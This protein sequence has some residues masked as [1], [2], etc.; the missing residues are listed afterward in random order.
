MKSIFFCLTFVCSV[1][2]PS[3]PYLEYLEKYPTLSAYMGNADEGEIEIILD[4]QKRLE[5]EQQMKR[6]VGIVAED[7]YWL[8]INDAVK[9]PSGKY[10][11]YARLLC[12]QSLTGVPGVAVMVVLPNGKIALN[13][14]FRH[15][16]RSWEYELPRGGRNENESIEDA[17][18]REVKEETGMVVG[19]LKLL[20]QMTPDSGLTNSVVPVFLAK[21][22]RQED[23]QPEDSEAIAGIDAFSIAEL[24][25]GFMDGYLSVT[26]EGKVCKIPLRDSF[27]AFALL[28]V[29]IRGLLL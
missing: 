8:W 22:I 14:N 6:K 23:A 1:L 15:A 4:S 24:K 29:E 7:A 18:L 28:Q 27:L 21:I 26:I 16:T 10:G 2:L 13:R 3:D 25:Q 5:I 17:A 11:I 19:D 12:R 20:G 9:F